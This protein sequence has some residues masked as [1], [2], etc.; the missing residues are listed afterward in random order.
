MC[1]LDPSIDDSTQRQ[2]D[3]CVV[4]VFAGNEQIEGH[5]PLTKL[6][7]AAACGSPNTGLD[8]YGN[9]TNDI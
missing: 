6:S 8:Q 1:E 5:K 3:A 9:D 7:G 2:I 4:Y